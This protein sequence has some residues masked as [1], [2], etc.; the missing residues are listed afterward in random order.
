MAPHLLKHPLPLTFMSDRQKGLDNA[1][2]AVFGTVNQRFC[3]RHMV[4][5]LHRA[6]RGIDDLVWAAAKAWKVTDFNRAMAVI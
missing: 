3:F 2:H 1:V 5:N 4:K 6:W